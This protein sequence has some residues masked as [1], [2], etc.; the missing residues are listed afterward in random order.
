MSAELRLTG[1]RAWYGGVQALWDVDLHIPPGTVVTLLG[2]NGAGK[3]TLLRAISG[4]VRRKGSILLDGE[5]IDTAPT[6]VIARAGVGAVP[7]DRGTIP[8]LTVAE[9]LRVGAVAAGRR[10]SGDAFDQVMA[11][12][13]D[14]SGMLDRPAQLLS[15]GQQQMLAIGRALM[16]RPRVLLL[17]EPSQGLAPVVVDAIFTALGTLAQSGLGLLIAEQ[18]TK[19]G[20]ALAHEVMVLGSGRVRIRG[21]AAELAGSPE[22]HSAYLGGTSGDSS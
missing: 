15:G 7:Q 19:G 17:D 12:F 13:P 5:R 20:F 1:V 22:I 4:T 9:N 3:T 16:G 11:L 18:N 14:L 10:R 21:T 8:G 6:H 2:P